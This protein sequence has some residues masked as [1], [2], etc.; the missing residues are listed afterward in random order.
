[1]MSSTSVERTSERVPAL[2]RSSVVLTLLSVVFFLSGFS[3]LLYQVVWQRLL[4]LYYGVGA[5]S[6]TVIVSVYMLGLGGGALIGAALAERVIRRIRLYAFVELAIACFGV[7]SLPFLDELG[8]R[9]AG[10]GY[11]VTF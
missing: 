1:M 10:S 9:T 2:A 7:L 6:I 8:V 3:A 4:T 5:V 11:G